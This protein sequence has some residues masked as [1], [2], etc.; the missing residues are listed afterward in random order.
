M[1]QRAALQADINQLRT[2]LRSAPATD[3]EGLEQAGESNELGMGA[4]QEVIS[5]GSRTIDP[6][7]C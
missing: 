2:E 5:V 7:L 1:D 4:I 6:S 3:D